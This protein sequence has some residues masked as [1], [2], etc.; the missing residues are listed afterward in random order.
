[1]V[2]T[3]GGEVSAREEGAVG[4]G[5]SFV[6]R[7]FCI[8]LAKLGAFILQSYSDDAKLRRSLHMRSDVWCACG[9]GLRNFLKLGLG[10]HPRRK[11]ALLDP[12]TK[13]PEHMHQ[14]ITTA[15]PP[16]IHSARRDAS[17]L[18]MGA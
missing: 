15:K 17:E 5:V 9:G 2:D 3:S 14:T 1:V 6:A 11:T 13:G 4:C 7:S 8:S 18:T 10:R 16:L 12:C